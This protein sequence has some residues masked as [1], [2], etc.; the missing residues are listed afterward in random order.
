MQ[1]V[2]KNLEKKR[3]FQ[4]IA[5]VVNYVTISKLNVSRM[6]IDYI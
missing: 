6:D 2:I 3:D 1:S 5:M 4:N